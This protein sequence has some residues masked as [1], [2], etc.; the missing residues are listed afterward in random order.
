MPNS[1][2]SI[3]PTI[4]FSIR[5]EEM[6]GE[7]QVSAS[8]NF[9]LFNYS[10]NCI[11]L[12]LIEI[13]LALKQSSI[14]GKSTKKPKKRKAKSESEHNV[15]DEEDVLRHMCEYCGYR[16]RIRGNLR[17]HKRRHTGE[18]PFSCNICNAT[19]AARYQLT[20][21]CERHVDMHLRRN[22]HW[23]KDCNL[24]FL[25][26]RALYHHRPLHAEVK[27]YKCNLCNKSYAQAA[28]FAQHKRWHRSRNEPVTVTNKPNEPTVRKTNALN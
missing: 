12:I 17:V 2:L 23:C 26:S 6:V 28:G 20:T 19:F 11:I 18:K 14:S 3:M 8:F 15:T 4:K 10:F 9:I 1:T 22:R 21:H 27:K 13:P 24:G 16:T 25:S 7:V 5:C